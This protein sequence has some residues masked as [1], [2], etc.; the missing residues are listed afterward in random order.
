MADDKQDQSNATGSGDSGYYNN[1]YGGVPISGQPGFTTPQNPY[2]TPLGN[3]APNWNTGT[4]TVN[5]WQ[6]LGYEGGSPLHNLL[7]VYGQQQQQ[8]GQQLAQMPEFYRGLL[9]E[10]QTG[11]REAGAQA[12]QQAGNWLAGSGLGSL[13]G[14][15][16]QLTGVPF[17]TAQGLQGA[18]LQNQAAL[19]QA[20][21]QAM[22]AQQQ[23]AA[24]AASVEQQIQARSSQVQAGVM[25]AM[26]NE[27]TNLLNTEGAYSLTS[28][29]WSAIS[30]YANGLIQQVLMYDATGGAQGIPEAQA[31]ASL[32][33][34][35]RNWKKQMNAQ[36]A[37]VKVGKY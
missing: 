31:T 16:G 30:N 1:T 37:D 20:Q 24:G 33:G 36:G 27:I 21:A 6:G 34:F 8:Y 22:G 32:N 4:M 7:G 10:A 26:E 28:D 5:P 25:A 13:S 3:P 14:V 23:A 11:V 29:A 15:A 35:L 17:Q 2:M 19:Q 9:S 12:G 18:A